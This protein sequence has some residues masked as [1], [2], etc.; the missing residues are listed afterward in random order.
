MSLLKDIKKI[1]AWCN[2]STTD[3]G[4]VS[5]GS[6]PDVPTNIF[7]DMKIEY[8]TGHYSMEIDGV[9][10]VDLSREQQIKIVHELVDK[11]KDSAILQEIV[12]RIMESI[13]D[14][15]NLGECETC[16]DYIEKYTYSF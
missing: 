14:Y 10:F 12:E 5:L 7:K 6:N 15:E 11:V 8:M 4:S 16:G 9:E 2:G 1:G 13:G 3:F